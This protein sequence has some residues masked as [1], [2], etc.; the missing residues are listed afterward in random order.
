MLLLSSTCRRKGTKAQSIRSDNSVSPPRSQNRFWA[1]YCRSTKLERTFNLSKFIDH[2]GGRRVSGFYQDAPVLGNQYEEDRLLRSYLK[3][4]LPPDMLEAIEPELRE[5]AHR[6][7][8][9]IQGWAEDAETHP[10]VHTPYD[11]WGRRVDTVQ[12]AEGWRRLRALSAES[13]FVAAAYER[14]F[15][16]LSRVYQH[17]L[18]Y[19]FN[20]ASAVYTCPL[21]MTDGGARLI[22]LYARDALSEAFGRLTARDPARFWTSGQWMTERTGGSD[23][24]RT[25]TR[26]VPDGEDCYRLHG[27]KWFTSAVTSDVAMTLARIEGA[28]AG[29]RGLSLF[30]LKVYDDAGRLRDIEI[31]RLKDKLG[32]R[33]LPTAELTLTGTCAQRIG[34]PGEGVRQITS[35]LNVTRIWN[36]NAAVSGMRRGVALAQAYAKR[37][38]AFGRPLCALPLHRETLADLETERCGAFHLLFRTAELQ[39]RAECGEAGVPERALLRLLTPV[40][41]LYTGKQVVSVTSEVLEAFGGAGYLEDTGLPRMLRDAQT[42][43]IWEGTTNVLSLDVLRVLTREPDAMNA[44]LS[45]V[46]VALQEAPSAELAEA[47]KRIR[48]ALVKIR[49]YAAS[50]LTM[51]R[52]TLEAG[53]RRFSYAL[54]R[55]FAGALLVE[56][57]AWALEREPA[58]AAA[59]VAA[60][61]RWCRRDLAPLP[62]AAWSVDE[63]TA[64]L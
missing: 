61:R 41:K 24:G 4:Q 46:D 49:S 1:G 64:L 19:L 12:V 39:G 48:R 63:A 47:A 35:L 8:G 27:T 29:S 36:A 51:E 38:W 20:P 40:L 17:A 13:G 16:G 56:H 23:V 37:R 18:L 10:P 32:T 26:A 59:H 52:E 6:V 7:N 43:S 54:A 25:E 30:Y 28:E 42:L 34:K 22:E 15:G 9:D 45:A 55:T 11:P 60:A 31:N 5:L 57:A 62:E 53:A 3:R 44:Y 33:A 14:R 2:E 50:A 21:A 58:L